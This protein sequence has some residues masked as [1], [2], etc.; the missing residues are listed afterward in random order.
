MA[1]DRIKIEY[2]HDLKT[3]EVHRKKLQGNEIIEDK[4]V[5]TW[6]DD[7]QTLT[8]PSAN[9]TRLYK[10]G[11]TTFLAEDEKSVR[12]FQRGDLPADAPL[13]PKSSKVPP[14]PKKT[15]HEGDK[16][17][18]VVEW[19][20]KYRYNEFCTRYGVLGKYTGM[21]IIEVPTWE[22]RP[23]DGLPEYRGSPRHEKAVVDVIVA[24]R[25]THL[26]YTPDECV[27]FS[28]DDEEIG[29]AAAA[30]RNN[31]EGDDE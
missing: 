24:T 22:P 2:L 9:Y 20:Q 11:V 28:D 3:K 26:T 29:E 7:T 18:A 5:A 12:H 16:T 27:D 23:V 21:V 1:D 30:G 4:V 25:K 10:Q 17:P 13:D 14:R 8:F 19:Y 6:D 31:A 15:K